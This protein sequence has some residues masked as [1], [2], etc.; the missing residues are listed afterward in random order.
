MPAV[1]PLVFWPALSWA[2]CW[3]AKNRLEWRLI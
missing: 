1:I 2:G 3:L